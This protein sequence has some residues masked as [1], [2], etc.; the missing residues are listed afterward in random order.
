MRARFRRLPFLTEEA[1][2]TVAAAGRI[3]MILVFPSGPW[4]TSPCA[5][6]EVAVLQT[7]PILCAHE[8]ISVACPFDRSPL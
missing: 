7:D 4:G 5:A 8:L 3:A 2:R 1:G 6:V